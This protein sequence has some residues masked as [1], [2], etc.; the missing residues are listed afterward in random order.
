MLDG[1]TSPVKSYNTITKSNKTPNTSAVADFRTDSYS[2]DPDIIVTALTKGVRFDGHS[3][4]DSVTRTLENK[5]ARLCGCQAS[6][7]LPTDA[8]ANVIAAQLLRGNSHG[9]PGMIFADAR[10]RIFRKGSATS[11]KKVLL[12]IQPGNNLF[13][14]KE[15]LEKAVLGRQSTFGQ[16]SV[17]DSDAVLISLEAAVGGVIFDFSEMQRISSFARNRGFKLHLDGTRIWEVIAAELRPLESYCSLFDSISLSF[18]KALGAP[19]GGMLVGTKEFISEAERVK[20]MLGGTLE[21]TDVISAICT[22]VL[23]KHFCGNPA[24]V[25]QYLEKSHVYAH[26][27]A[28]YWRREC[29]GTLK[30]PTETNV[31]WL[32]LDEDDTNRLVTLAWQ[33]GLRIDGAR[34][35]FHHCV[36]RDAV[37]LV[38]ELLRNFSSQRKSNSKVLLEARAPVHVLP[39][40]TKMISQ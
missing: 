3:G 14:T 18:S 23:D 29:K 31:A 5:V 2:C 36:S 28:V 19:F 35:M 7:F 32:D 26:E 12:P 9:L 33:Y 6:L 21:K 13:L 8:M 38:K 30:Y 40:Q 10:S 25:K 37:E 39:A 27:I 4:D 20:I 17:G 1:T 34:L 16:R 15:D 24:L 11:S 22:D